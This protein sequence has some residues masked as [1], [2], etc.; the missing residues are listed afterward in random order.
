MERKKKGREKDTADVTGQRM[1]WELVQGGEGQSL[2][3]TGRKQDTA[4]KLGIYSTY[5]QEAQYSS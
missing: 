5:P 1:G 2:A 3:R 4:T